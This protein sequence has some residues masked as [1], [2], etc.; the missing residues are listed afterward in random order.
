MR[1]ASDLERQY[2]RRCPVMVLCMGSALRNGDTGIFAGTT[3]AQRRKLARIRDRV[4]CPKCG[5][6]KL[7]SV[8]VHDICAAC[9]ASWRTE[10]KNEEGRDDG[11][12]SH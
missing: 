10:R 9:G 5:C 8:D 3:T 12:D 2:C 6:G 11:N 1:I 4:K 7:V